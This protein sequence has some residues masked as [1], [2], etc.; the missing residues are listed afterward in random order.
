LPGDQSIATTHSVE[1]TRRMRERAL[2]ERVHGVIPEPDAHSRQPAFEGIHERLQSR[3]GL[4][5]VNLS[6]RQ[7]LELRHSVLEDCRPGVGTQE[8]LTGNGF[9]RSSS[10]GFL[11]KFGRVSWSRRDPFGLGRRNPFIQRITVRAPSGNKI[12][13]SIDSFLG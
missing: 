10:L 5:G 9:V 11:L 3:M 13:K 6:L 8:R 2:K 12:A 1:E 7:D 4:S